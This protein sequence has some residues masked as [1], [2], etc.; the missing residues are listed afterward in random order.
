MNIDRRGGRALF[1][2][3]E[4]KIR[5]MG[6][7]KAFPFYGSG[8][9]EKAEVG[10]TDERGGGIVGSLFVAPCQSVDT[11]GRGIGAQI[12]HR[13]SPSWVTGRPRKK[14]EEEVAIVLGFFFLPVL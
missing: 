7:A 11:G 2:G 10:T 12:P 1:F 13:P 14:K 6:R 4:N 3:H 5:G 8:G 9:E